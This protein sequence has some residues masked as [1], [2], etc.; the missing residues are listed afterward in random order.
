MPL[1]AGQGGRGLRDRVTYGGTSP[2]ESS[3]SRARGRLSTA[4]AR[5][6]GPL[7]DRSKAI[8]EGCTDLVGANFARAD[9]E[10]AGRVGDGVAELHV[11]DRGS[12]RLDDDRR[13]VVRSG[14]DVDR[15]FVILV[16]AGS[17]QHRPAVAST[18]DGVAEVVAIFASRGRDQRRASWTIRLFLFFSASATRVGGGCTSFTLFVNPLYALFPSS[19]GSWSC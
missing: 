14:V 3:Y 4:S 13:G 18:G 5:C 9:D 11:I 16:A 19:F 15:T 17:H 12:W 10:L 7:V 2:C 1:L 8:Q 6:S